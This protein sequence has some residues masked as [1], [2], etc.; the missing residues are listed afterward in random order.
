[1]R[2]KIRCMEAT[3]ESVE[4]AA[5]QLSVNDRAALAHLLLRN[6]DET[7]PDNSGFESLWVE[8]SE[9]RLDAYLDGEL[10][11]SPLD[12]TVQRVR[13]GIK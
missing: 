1:M 6:L 7:E 9:D 8:E 11:A 3:L 12:E 13:A 5:K 10:E 4:L 2:Y